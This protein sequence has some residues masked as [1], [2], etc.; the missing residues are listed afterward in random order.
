MSTA[1]NST[2]NRL[3]GIASI[4][5]AGV[6]Y[7]LQGE[8]KWSPSKVDRETLI[9]MDAVHGYKE[10][11]YASFIEGVLRDNNGLTVG[12]FNNM[13][14]VNLTLQLANG[15]T[16]TGSNMWCVKAQEVNSMEATF[17]VRFEGISGAVTESAPTV[18][19][20]TAS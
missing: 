12:D 16:V 15:K 17:D 13:T 4:T 7:L 11:P 20:V 14:S 18:T 19:P 8:L 9:G 3:A 5:V 1:P 6:T 10:T 2:V